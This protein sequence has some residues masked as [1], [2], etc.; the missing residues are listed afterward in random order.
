MKIKKTIFILA[1]ILNVLIGKAEIFSTLSIVELSFYADTVVEA[2]FLKKEEED[3][4]FLIE[5]TNQK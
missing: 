2:T 5:N 1:C 4:I 3:Y